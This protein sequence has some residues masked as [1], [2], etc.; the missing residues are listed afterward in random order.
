MKPIKIAFLL[1]LLTNLLFAQSKHNLQFEKIDHLTAQPDDW[2]LSFKYGGAQGYVAKIDSTEFTEGKYSLTMLPNEGEN[3]TFGACAYIIPASYEGSTIELRGYL[4]TKDISFDGLAGLWLRLDGEKGVYG[5]DNM[6]DRRILG[7]NDWKEYS[8]KLPLEDEV[9][10]IMVGGMMA[11]QGQIWIDDLRLFIDGKPLEQ[12]PPKKEKIYPA[13]LDSTFFYGSNIDLKSVN[14]QQTKDLAL[15]AKIWGFVKYYHPEVAKGTHNMDA[16]LFRILPKVMNSKNADKRDKAILKWIESLGEIPKCE[17]CDII[18]ADNAKMTPDLKWM[19]DS[20]LSKALNKKLHYLFDNRN[21]GKHF[22]ISMVPGIQNPE[23]K[24]EQPYA[25]F[26]YPD[27]GYR[28]LTLYKYWNII[29]YFFP[30]KYVIGKDWHEV[31]DEFIPKFIE[32][33]DALA[34]HMETLQLIG[35]IHDTHANIWSNSTYLEEFK[36][37]L[38]PAVQVKFI[39]EQLVV[40]GYYHDTLGP[41][42]GLKAGDIILTIDG[43]L[44]E[45]LEKK[46]APLHPASNYPTKLRNIAQTILRGN[47]ETLEVTVSRG[48]KKYH[49]EV[50]RHERKELQLGKDWAYNKPDSC[51][52]LLN[53]DIGYLY[54]GNIKSDLLPAAFELFKDTK[55]LV[56]D[57]RNY[58]SEFVVFTLGAYLHQK[59][60]AF[61]KFTNGDV[62]CPGL[63]HWGPDLRIGFNNPDAYQG[64]VVIL[65]NEISQSQAEYTTMAFRSAPNVMVIG[66]TTAGADGNVSTFYL[67]GN[68]RTRI[69]GIGVYY[70]DGTQTQRVGIVPDIEVKPTIKGVREGRDELLEKAME[71]I[72][73][74]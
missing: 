52:Q 69:S 11:G 43:Q 38:Q 36:G 26:E 47:N 54:L 4:K 64:K 61:V 24:N 16:E 6:G 19:D 33:P 51:Y 17:T 25:H 5:F 66:S 71:I 32:A 62:S 40:T 49:L 7:T 2:D 28:L 57:I 72:G 58:P 63:F 70:P 45:D 67:P 37:N 3:Q 44:V 46:W 59:S 15:L 55:G 42:S 20:G 50:K 34:Y 68:I 13:T 8:I 12:A 10:K 14:D 73:K 21:Q 31:L 22:Y 53:E 1:T 48:M 60:T 30:Y 27:T 65:I 23:F 29:H 9:T 35:N 74:E 18:Y 39:E 56:I 41:E